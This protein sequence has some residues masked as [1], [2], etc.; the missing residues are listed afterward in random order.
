M[1]AGPMITELDVIADISRR[2]E[3]LGIHY[4]L[5]GSVAMNYYAEPRMTRDIDIVVEVTTTDAARLVQELSPDY[6]I[7]VDTVKEAV[8]NESMF[9]ILHLEGVIK[10]DCIIRKSSEYRGLEFNRRAKI[11]IGNAST[12]IVSKE[13]LILSKLY[14]ARDSRS[15]M[16]IKDVKNLMQSGYD[17]EYLETWAEILGI[18]EVYREC[19]HG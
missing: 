17:A 18:A 1:D 14:W 6:Y 3:L 19:R 9:N 12:Y 7:D 16:Q 5:T 8:A 10:V 4:M 15:E 13:D 11:K 2:L